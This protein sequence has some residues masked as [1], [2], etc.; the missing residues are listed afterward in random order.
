VSLIEAGA[1]TD[2]LGGENKNNLVFMAASVNATKTLQLLIKKAPDQINAKNKN[3]DTAL[4]EAARFGSEKTLEILLK[5]GAKKDLGNNQGKTALD[6]ARSIN[7]EVAM[8]IL[9]QH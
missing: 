5:A 4:H 8:K 7:N 3:G 2:V 1:K 9:V 6:I